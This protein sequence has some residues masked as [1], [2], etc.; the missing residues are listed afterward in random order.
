[1]NYESIWTPALIAELTRLWNEDLPT[2]E[3]GRRLSISKN[4]VIGKAHRLSLAARPSPIRHT[5]A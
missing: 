1:M 5:A 3:I 4:C 2:A